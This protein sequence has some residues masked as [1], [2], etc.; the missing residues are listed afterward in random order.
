MKKLAALATGACAV[1]TVVTTLAAQGPAA[2]RVPPL[3]DS[4]RNEEQQKIAA[5]FAATGMPNA[6]A[7][8]LH[9]LR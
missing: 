3:P 5:E 4:Q 9:Y 7:T 8:Y 1:L 2:P 6:V